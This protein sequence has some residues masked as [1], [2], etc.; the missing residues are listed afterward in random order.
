VQRGPFAS[1]GSAPEQVVERLD[2]VAGDDHLVQDVALLEG[3]KRESL[4]VRAVLN[5]EDRVALHGSLRGEKVALGGTNV[6]RG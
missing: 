2:A 3:A 1:G 5:K 4:V 6:V